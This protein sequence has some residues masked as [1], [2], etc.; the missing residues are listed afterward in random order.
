MGDK[1]FISF[2]AKITALIYEF[3]WEITNFRWQCLV[4]DFLTQ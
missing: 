3:T 1:L 2:G 4:Q